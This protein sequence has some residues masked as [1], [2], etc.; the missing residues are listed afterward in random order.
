MATP[1]TTFS[2]ATLAYATL[3]KADRAD[4]HE[5]A[6][7]WIDR[8]GP[9]DDAIAGCHLEQ[10]VRSPARTRKERPR[11]DSA[12]IA[13]GD[14]GAG[15][16][17]A[18]RRMQ[19]VRA[20]SRLAA[21]GDRAAS[22]GARTP[23]SCCWE[24]ALALW[25]ESAR[26]EF[27]GSPLDRGPGGRRLQL[28]LGQFWHVAGS[29]GP[30]S[31]LMRNGDLELADVVAEL[32]AATKRLERERDRARPGRRSQLPRGGLVPSPAIMGESGRE[33]ERAAAQ[34]PR[35]AGSAPPVPASASRREGPVLRRGAGGRGAPG[36]VRS[37]LQDPPDRMSEANV[38]GVVAAL[39][40]LVGEIDRGSQAARARSHA[41]TTTS[42]TAGSSTR[43]S[44]GFRLEIEMLAGRCR[45]R[46]RAQ[47]GE[48]C[49][50]PRRR[51]ARTCDRPRAGQLAAFLLDAEPNIPT[52]RSASRCGSRRGRFCR[53]ARCFRPVSYGGGVRARLLGAPGRARGGR[54][55]SREAPLSISLLRSTVFGKRSPRP[56]GVGGGPDARGP[57]RRG[58]RGGQRAPVVSSSKRGRLRFCRASM[59][60]RLRPGVETREEPLPEL[61]SSA[62]AASAR[63]R[64]CHRLRASSAWRRPSFRAPTVERGPNGPVTTP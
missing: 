23:L 2:S 11:T 18:P 34:L 38:T 36:A 56:P 41:S 22:H 52:R 58:S 29:R 21:A 20:G 37:L 17:C 3:T 12:G 10:A 24:L 30:I 59:R 16:A 14:P 6:A 26:E 55:P 60:C 51:S 63:R 5:R 9:G 44:D 31:A 28:A 50:A 47:P 49:R 19:D 35:A 62:L 53:A 27:E 54:R 43:A 48:R 13:G 7:A 33:G 57:A 40:A 1:S 64:R 15:K 42:E 46:R 39:R 25:L 32:T 8:D 4:L 61:F 45:R